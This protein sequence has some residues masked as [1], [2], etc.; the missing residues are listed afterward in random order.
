MRLTVPKSLMNPWTPG[1][2][3]ILAWFLGEFASEGLTQDLDQD[4]EL[5]QDWEHH[6]ELDPGM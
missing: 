2:S 5:G 1:V 6:L 4:L 3:Q